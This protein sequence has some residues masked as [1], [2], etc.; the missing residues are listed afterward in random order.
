[1]FSETKKG[2]AAARNRGIKEATGEYI[3]FVDSD[4]YVAFNSYELIMDKMSEMKADLACF[5][6]NCVD[7]NG[8]PLNWYE[9]K[10]RRYRKK[11][12][13]GKDIAEIFLTSLDIEGFCWNK[14]FK[15]ELF[16]Q[17]N[18]YFEENKT[19]FEDMAI[20]FDIICKSNVR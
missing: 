2:A 15:K 1:M 5:S 10:L 8:N 16:I 20:I 19:A 14:V 6:F 7:N 4:D 18:I 3:T 11:I 17:N 9:P 13:D 12:F